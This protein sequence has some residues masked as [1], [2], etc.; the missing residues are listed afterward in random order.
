MGDLH[1]C[2]G[3]ALEVRELAVEC[4]VVEEASYYVPRVVEDNRDVEIFSGLN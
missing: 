2:S 4:G 1:T 3:I